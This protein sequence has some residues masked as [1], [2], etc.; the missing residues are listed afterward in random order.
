[1][2]ALRKPK[3]YHSEHTSTTPLDR[4]AHD[5]P[6]FFTVVAHPSTPPEALQN[7]RMF[8]LYQ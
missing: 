8:W 2:C 7:N 4:R 5:D 6:N 1:M 3:P